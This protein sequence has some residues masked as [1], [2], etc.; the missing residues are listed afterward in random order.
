MLPTPIRRPLTITAWIALSV[1]VLA[2]SPLLLALSALAAAVLRRPSP[3]LV[4]RIL[5]AY[6]ARELAVLVSCGL[7]WLL[8]GFGIRMRAPYFQRLH[9]R[10][11]RWLVHGIAM[12]A[13]QLLDVDVATT[14]SPE[15][16]AAMERD[17]PLLFFSRH[18][19]PGDSV[20]LVDLLLTRYHRH[21]SVVFKETLAID[22]CV[23]LIGH[24]LPHA[25][26]DTSEPEKCEQRIAEV[27]SRLAPQG[28][29][30]LFPEGANYSA[31]RRRRALGKLWRKG[32]RREAEAGERMRHVLPPRPGGALAALRGNPDA[33]VVFAA[34]TGLGL[35][36]FP[37]EIWRNPPIGRTLTTRM[38]LAPAAD[39]PHDPDEQ[40]KWLY[41]W[42]KRLDEWVEQQGQER[43][44]VPS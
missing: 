16:T 8:S 24:R 4:C 28:V 23:D 17:R 40:V 41:D 10:L 33:D 5:I 29:L 31:P 6:C 39:R 25:L 34:H 21:P 38:W 18:A 1:V 42:W 26:L 44:P 19:G 9:Y 13:R 2:L 30:L 27:A 7:L 43:A 20:L 37:S 35:A 3:L 11:L 12:R 15:A 32:Q 14:G 22:P 36:V